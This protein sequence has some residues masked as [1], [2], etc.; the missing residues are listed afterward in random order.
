MYFKCG[1]VEE[2]YNMFRRMKEMNVFS[3]SSTIVGFAVHDRAHVAIKLLYESLETAIKPNHVT[4][5]SLFTACSHAGM[6]EQGQQLFGAMEECYGVAPTADHYACKLI[7]LAEQDTWKKHSSLFRQCLRSPMDM[8]AENFLEHHTS[9]GSLMLL[10][11]LLAFCL[12]L[13]LITWGIIY[14]C[15]TRMH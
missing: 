7:F 8:C 10:K 14:C 2:A 15:P 4:F 12:S 3:Y 1:N 13:N 9:T 5:V 6:V 11:L